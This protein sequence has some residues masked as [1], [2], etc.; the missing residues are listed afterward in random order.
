MT[1]KLSTNILGVFAL[2]NNRIIEKILFSKNPKEIS[3]KLLKISDGKILEEEEKLIRLLKKTGLKEISVKK[4]E[5]F[6]SLLPEIKFVEDKEK[7]NIVEIGLQLGIPKEEILNLSKEVNFELAKTKLKTQPKDKIIIQVVNTL[8]DLDETINL[9]MEHLR[10]WHSLTFPELND[11]VK[12]PEIYA[13]IVSAEEEELDPLL[14]KR[15]KDAKEK[16]L[17]MEFSEKDNQA[18]KNLSKEILNL[19]STKKEIENYI[20][21]LMQEITPNVSTLTGSLLGAKLI[22]LAGGLEKLALMPSSTIQ[23]LGAEEAFFKFLKSGKRPPKH[24]IIFQLPEIRSANKKIRG[25]LSRTLAAKI[26]IAAKTDFYKGEF[27][28]EKLREDFMKRVESL[29]KE[30]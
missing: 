8:D 1:I 23:I 29:K 28:G 16:S 27:I 19:Y 2:K 30:K 15:V 22:S 21:I 17:G 11:L 6:F 5:R 9:L 25:K 7:E 10:E 24:G 12:N 26:A 18:V 13:K 4:P 20:E 3:E 14:R